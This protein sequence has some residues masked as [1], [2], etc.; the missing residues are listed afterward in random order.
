[1]C[2]SCGFIY[3]PAEGILTAGFRPAPP[4]RTSRR[5][6]S[7]RC[8]APASRTSRPTRTDPGEQG[9]C[10][11]G[12]SLSAACSARCSW[13]AAAGGPPSSPRRLDSGD[14]PRPR[15]APLTGIHK[16]QHVVVIMQENRSFDSYFGTYP[17]ADGIPIGACHP[18]RPLHGLRA[19]VSRSPRPDPGGAAQPEQRPR[20]HGRRPHE[21]VHHAA[22]RAG[23]TRSTRVAQRRPGVLPDV[24]GYHTGAD[25]PNYWAYARDFVLQ[26]HMFQ[27][28]ASLEP[29]LT[30]VHGVRVVGALRRPREPLSCTQRAPG[31]AVPPDFQYASQPD[32]AWTD[33][34]Y[35]LHSTGSAGAITSSRVRARLRTERSDAC[36]PVPN[37]AAPR[38]SGTRCPT[39][40]RSTRTTS[41]ATSSR[42]SSSTAARA[43]SC[44]PCPGSPPTAGS[45][46]THPP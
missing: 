12:C 9:P 40:T 15:P 1:M 18:P 10:T 2:E 41:S 17:G 29:A 25:I 37:G 24:M 45:P 14:R 7:V 27:S 4:S 43:G 8:A 13:P 3:D 34:T 36:A 11:A 26:D 46:S 28:D 5:P 32:Y 6:G 23:C 22:G 31:P 42:S 21:R 30:P 38:G 19:P 16:I 33:I 20:R 35:L 44:R 39:S